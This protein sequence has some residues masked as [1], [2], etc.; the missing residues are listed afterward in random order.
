MLMTM[1]TDISN[2]IAT[3]RQ[4]LGISQEKLASELGVSFQTV[5]RWE[6]GHTKPSHLALVAIRQKLVE[7]GRVG[8][9][10]LSEY[11]GES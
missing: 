1:K 5:N 6:R 4:R 11:F 8:S 7:M 9:D 10:L 3:M 2:L